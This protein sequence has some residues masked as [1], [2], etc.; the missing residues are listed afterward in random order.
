MAGRKIDRRQFIEVTATLAGGMLLPSALG[1][2][3][4]TP[5]KRTATDQVKLGKT[6]IKLSRIGFGTGSHGGR[7]QRRLGQKGLTRLIRY[8]YD[9]GITY[10]DTADR[11]RTHTM[12]RG[13]IKGLPREKLFIQSKMW[14]VPDSP[15]AELDRFRK[16]LGVEYIDSLLLHCGVRPDWPEKRKKVIDALQEAK[17]KKLIRA[18]GISCHSLPAM[19]TAEGQDWLDVHLVRINPQGQTIDKADGSYADSKASDVPAAVAQIRRL[20]RT[21][22][23]II[24]MKLIGDG[25]FKKAED[26]EKSIRFAMTS[27]LLSAAVIGFKNTAEIDE[28]LERVNRALAQPAAKQS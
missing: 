25:H 19:K 16:E 27:G 17:Q 6:G 22:R 2:E 9:K 11:Y 3:A 8:A 12:I 10:I 20:T 14:G 4:K 1:A 15:A 21:K 5:T 7:D 13:A 18:I 23:G 26:R 28:A 24:G